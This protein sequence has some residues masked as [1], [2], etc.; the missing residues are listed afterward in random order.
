MGVSNIKDVEFLE[1]YNE[2][3]LAVLYEPS[4]TSTT[5]YAVSKNTSVVS[6]ITLDLERKKY[7]IAWSQVMRRSQL[8]AH[9]FSG[10]ASA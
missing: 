1:G 8:R 7:P 2:P 5:R 4:M 3:T 9:L 6:L 10:R